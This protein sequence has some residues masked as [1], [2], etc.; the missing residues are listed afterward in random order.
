VSTRAGWLTACVFSL[1]VA[2]GACDDGLTN[3]FGQRGT[4]GTTASTATVSGRVTSGAGGL[5]GVGVVLVGRDS[6]STDGTG[7]YAFRTVP[8]G[9]Y[10]VSVR[11]P[12]GFALGAGQTASQT[13]TVGA[14]GTATASWTVQQT[15]T[16]P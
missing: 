6:T 12:V 11:V 15:T 4:T 5:G 8:A 14:G 1:A 9:T 2:T 10:T 13:V 16:T 3:A 7:A